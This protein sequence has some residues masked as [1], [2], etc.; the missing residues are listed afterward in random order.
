ME[1]T[2]VWFIY[3]KVSQQAGASKEPIIL[4]N[5]D[6]DTDTDNNGEDNGNYDYDQDESW[7][8]CQYH[9]LL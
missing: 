9:L 5:D 8:W 7:W 1:W 2:G 3:K 6:F 4:D